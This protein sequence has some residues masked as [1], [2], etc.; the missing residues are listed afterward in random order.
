MNAEFEKWWNDLGEDVV[1]D[2]TM[3]K[4]IAYWAWCASRRVTQQEEVAARESSRRSCYGCFVKG[5]TVLLPA[6]WTSEYCEKCRPR[7]NSGDGQK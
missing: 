5:K 1:H 6:G 4:E 2:A 3:P 7:R